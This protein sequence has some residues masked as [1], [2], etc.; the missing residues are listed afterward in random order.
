M[1]ILQSDRIWGEDSTKETYG[2]M[3]PWPYGTWLCGDRRGGVNLGGG[4]GTAEVRPG[5]RYPGSSGALV[6][7]LL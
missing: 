2:D 7:V 1:T 6:L 5:S 3:L 4:W